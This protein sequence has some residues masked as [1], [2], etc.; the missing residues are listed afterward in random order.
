[1]ISKELLSEVLKNTVYE[2]NDDIIKVI[3]DIKA[4]EVVF[5]TDEEY[6]N[7]VNIYELMHKCKEWASSLD[8]REYW[9][10]SWIEQ[11]PILAVCEVDYQSDNKGFTADTEPEAIFKACEWILENS[12]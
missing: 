10:Q 2:E 7:S 9:L 4:N 1:M 3:Y 8:G 6:F 12:P 5:W 11:S